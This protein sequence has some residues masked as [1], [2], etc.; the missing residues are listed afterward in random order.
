MRVHRFCL[1][2]FV[3]IRKL[4]NNYCFNWKE[5]VNTEFCDNSIFDQQTSDP[6][7][8]EVWPT[9]RKADNHVCFY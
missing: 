6:T 9:D 3:Y 5:L 2:V 4:T 1:C 7:T 8:K